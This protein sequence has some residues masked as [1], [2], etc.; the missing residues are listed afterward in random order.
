MC[1]R[2]KF[3]NWSKE[4]VARFLGHIYCARENASWKL[5]P[6]SR[7]RLAREHNFSNVR[8]GKGEGASE[9]CSPLRPSGFGCSRTFPPQ[10]GCDIDVVIRFESSLFDKQNLLEF[11]N[12]RTAFESKGGGDVSRVLLFRE[13]KIRRKRISGQRCFPPRYLRLLRITCS[14]I[15]AKITIA[16]SFVDECLIECWRNWADLFARKHG[17]FTLK[18]EGRE[19]AC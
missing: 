7:T 16:Y 14:P 9:V 12:F 6:S 15:S 17:Q 2:R 8:E 13:A 19:I 4:R 3:R 11:V 1:S 10:L 18:E 5:G